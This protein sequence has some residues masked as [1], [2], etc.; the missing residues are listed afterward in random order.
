MKVT[1]DACIFGAWLDMGTGSKV[2][3]VGT[4]CGILSLMIA[5]RFRVSIDALEIDE[6]AALQAGENFG[7]S[8]WRR[9]ICIHHVSLSDFVCR[10]ETRP[11]YDHVVCNPPFY[12]QQS[13]SVDLQKRLA[14]HDDSLDLEDLVDSANILLNENGALHVMVPFAAKARLETI[15]RSRDFFPYAECSIRS[16]ADRPPHRLFASFSR[17]QQPLSPLEITIYEQEKI[18]TEACKNLL[19]PFL[20]HL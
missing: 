12:H 1:T 9:Q 14:W 3:D 6:Q 7:A 2:A 11:I 4:G 19:Q 8:P 18:Y 17:R 20:L 13:R 15:C 5:Q 10:S 16:F